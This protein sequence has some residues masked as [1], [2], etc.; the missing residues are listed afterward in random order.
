M[1]STFR[2]SHATS[3]NWRI[4]AERCLEDLSAAG[5][6][7]ANLGFLYATDA[8]A[9]SM[10][11]MLEFFRERT[12]CLHW[13]G[14]VGIGICANDTEYLNQPAM[15]V[16]LGE[17]AESS[18]QVFSGISS[19]QDVSARSF[20]CDG[21]A[22][23]FAIIHGDP[24][25]SEVAEIISGIA[26]KMDSGFIVGGLTSSRR[27]NLQVADDIASGGVSG[28]L[29]SEDVMIATRLTQG[30]TPIGA[31]HAI[32]Q[33]QRNILVTLD[34]RPALEV[35]KEDIG[36][37]LGEDLQGLGNLIFAGLPV[38][39]TDTDDYLARNLVGLD[40]V[41]GLIAVGDLVEEGQKI[42][43][44]R[45]DRASAI[46]DMDRMLASMKE[47]LFGR[48]RGGVYYS[49]LGRGASLFG[50][51]SQELKMIQKA[52]GDIPLVGFFGNGEISHNRL[53]G[54][55]G[56]LTLFT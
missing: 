21:N 4:A 2:A 10:D 8:Y 26:G 23:N 39:S 5:S 40:S 7:P 47:G 45:R 41:R 49:C 37:T 17:F 50:N 55:T 24:R 6:A 25:N 27:E 52:M 56:V 30:C 28:V 12:G 43:F 54:Y 9:D 20:V 31:K 38:T 16:M 53:Y 22:A 36:E 3:S 46:L 1:A 44:C 42:L 14:S 11:D 35:L 33:S 48:P 29:F 15:A 19:M 34:N 18:F 32:T 13:V 51:E